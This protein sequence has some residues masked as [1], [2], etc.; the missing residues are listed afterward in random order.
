MGPGEVDEH[1][2]VQGLGHVARPAPGPALVAGT[3]RTLSPGPLQDLP[4]GGLAVRP[5]MLAQEVAFQNWL[6][7]HLLDAMRTFDLSV[8]CPGDD[9]F[10]FLRRT[11]FG[12]RILVFGVR[13]KMT[14]GT[15]LEP[16]WHRPRPSSA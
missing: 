1:V 6:Q 9:A 16:L 2:P 11:R 13:V 10:W 15:V 12:F 5:E 14:G 7:G 8:L 4:D 3:Q